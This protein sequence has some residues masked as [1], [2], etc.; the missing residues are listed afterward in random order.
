MKIKRLKFIFFSL[1]MIMILTDCLQALTIKI[2][3]IAPL[4]SPWVRELKK[5]GLEWTKI[6]NGK[7]TLKIYA[8]GIAG[9]EDD[10]V[11]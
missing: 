4:R 1:I 6:T 8:G 11:R 5:L 10:M 9:G 2:G 7:V 3:T